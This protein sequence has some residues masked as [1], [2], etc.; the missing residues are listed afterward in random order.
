MFGKN[1][2][3]IIYKPTAKK[4]CGPKKPRP[5]QNQINRIVEGISRFEDEEDLKASRKFLDRDRMYTSQQG[6]I[7]LSKP[8][9]IGFISEE[10]NVRLKKEKELEKEQ[11]VAKQP[12]DII[13]A[14]EVLPAIIDNNLQIKKQEIQRFN[15]KLQQA[16]K[17][18]KESL[19][20]EMVYLNKDK[21]IREFVQ[22]VAG[23]GYKSNEMAF[24]Q[25]DHWITSGLPHILMLC[26]LVFLGMA[27][28]MTLI[29]SIPTGVLLVVGRLMLT[30]KR[31]LKSIPIIIQLRG[32]DDSDLC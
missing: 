16:I 10:E 23:A 9:T 7:T 8:T 29:F 13:L 15:Y 2:S 25:K 3:H 22:R 1:N 24:F 27:I 26:A 5:G 20:Y 32:I 6:A 18:K 11:E 12:T 19:H 21:D 17:E 30:E 4:V 31:S 14:C 28:P